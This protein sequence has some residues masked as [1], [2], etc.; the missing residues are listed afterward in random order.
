MTQI[1]NLLDSLVE[2]IKTYT[3][4]WTS[5]DCLKGYLRN[6][7]KSLTD[8]EIFR[9]YTEHLRKDKFIFD[10]KESYFSLTNSHLYILSKN[11]HDLE[12]RLDKYNFASKKQWFNT[13][14]STSGLLR[15]KNV[16]VLTNSDSE[17]ECKAVLTSLK[18]IGI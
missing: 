16:I 17:D 8:I 12:Y 2:R 3:I 14:F 1:N 4:K 7:Q 11:L 5:I 13:E 10:C 6:N 9:L 15:L 18:D